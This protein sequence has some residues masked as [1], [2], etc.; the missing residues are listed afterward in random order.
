M[1]QFLNVGIPR[2]VAGHRIVVLAGQHEPAFCAVPARA[3]HPE[4]GIVEL[5][6]IGIPRASSETGHSITR[7]LVPLHAGR[8][9]GAPLRTS[10]QSDRL[11]G[12]VHH[13]VRDQPCHNEGASG[14]HAP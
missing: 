12:L 4:N 2:H 1:H 14:E 3:P 9:E 5:T 6:Q 8:I 10:V 13:R 7:R 11:A